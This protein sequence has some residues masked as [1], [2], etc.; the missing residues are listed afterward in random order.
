MSHH[1]SGAARWLPALVG[2]RVGALT[3]ESLSVSLGSSDGIDGCVS[4]ASPV[5]PT[6]PWLHVG[7]GHTC[8]GPCP[9][10]GHGVGICPFS[11]LCSSSKDK[12]KAMLQVSR[13]QRPHGPQ[14]GPSALAGIPSSVGR[15]EVEPR[16]WAP[17]HGAGGV[18]THLSRSASCSRS[19]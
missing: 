7:G 5:S 18:C 10:R 14:A 11:F 19:T 6:H 3:G 16:R 17:H 15:G 2:A 8:T 13:G 4:T 1:P 12:S 9:G